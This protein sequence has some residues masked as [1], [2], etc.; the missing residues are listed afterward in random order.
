M[1]GAG[2]TYTPLLHI[3]DCRQRALIAGET[4]WGRML[5][6]INHTQNLPGNVTRAVSS[7]ESSS[8]EKVLQY[9]RMTEGTFVG[10]AFMHYYMTR[11]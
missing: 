6:V 2:P 11:L 3:W 8:E 1:L 7:Q 4:L 10:T 5:M 9:V